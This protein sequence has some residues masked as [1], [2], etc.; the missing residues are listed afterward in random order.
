LKRSSLF[1]ASVTLSVALVAP[2]HAQCTGSPIVVAVCNRAIDAVKTFH[3]VAGVL[4]SGGDP[5]LGGA[6]AM[7]G[8]GHFFVST[9]VNAVKITVPNPDTSAGP[10][11]IKGFTPAPVIE[12]G[13][14]LY[15]GL[16]SGLLALDGLFAATLVPTHAVD[17]LGVDS[18]ATKVGNFALG[19][20]YGVRIGIV[21]GLFP[22]PS[23]SMSV[24][25]RSLPRVTYGR[26]AASSLS[27]GDAFEFDADVKAT[28]WRFVAG[29][30]LVGFDVAAGIGFDRYTSHG[31]LRY[32]SNPP[33][34][35]IATV[36]FDPVNERQV[37]F[38]DAAFHLTVLTL[39]AEL[40]Y[41]TGENQKL[42]TNYSDFDPSKG[43]VF[44]GLG[45]R[46]GF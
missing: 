2:L 27:S 35:T 1:F 7:N 15:P 8:F 29:Y 17:K 25:R 18:G 28:N 38:A 3:P 37:V 5:V 13:V 26:L 39:G 32:Y 20:G 30:H 21:R 36:T 9:R 23:L 11:S 31:R 16:S 41:Q 42:S 40:G 12:G 22:I 44:G 43:H 33:L 46:F 14:G 24:M 19:L 10:T 45:I 4:I 6:R 34:N